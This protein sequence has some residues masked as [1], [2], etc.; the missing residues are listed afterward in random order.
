MGHCEPSSH[1]SGVRRAALALVV[2]LLAPHTAYGELA[3]G[4]AQFLPGD[5]A[6]VAAAGMQEETRIARG[7]N[8]FLAVWSD[9]RSSLDQYPPF[10]SGGIG[11]DVYGVLLDASGNVIGNSFPITDDF[12]DQIE[13]RVAWDGTSWPDACSYPAARLPCARHGTSRRRATGTF[14]TPPAWRISTTTALRTSSP[15]TGSGRRR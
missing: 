1:Q 3:F 12:G 10:A 8:Q 7:G 2:L 5:G 11:A 15:C 4:D 14:R 6:I 13:P 9:Y